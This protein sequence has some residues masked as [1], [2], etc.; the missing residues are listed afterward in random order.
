M[1]PRLLRRY[2]TWRQI[3]V[4]AL[5]F[6]VAAHLLHIAEPRLIAFWVV[7]T[8]L[9]TLQLFTFGT[10]LP[11]RHT[12]DAF[13][14]HHNARSSPFGPVLSLLTCFHFGR[15]HEHHL[16]PWKPWWRLRRASEVDRSAQGRAGA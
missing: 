2:I 10:W 9:S 1:V 5:T 11:H 12:D 3:A 16:T 8:L 13:P 14:D 6:N 4:M 7:P 15:H